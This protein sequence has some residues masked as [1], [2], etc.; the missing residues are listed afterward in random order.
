MLDFMLYVQVSVSVSSGSNVLVI[1]DMTME[2]T[3]RPIFEERLRQLGSW[4]TIN[5]Q[6]IYGIQSWRHTVFWPYLRIQNL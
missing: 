4:L 1:L 3:I 6:A 2:G 5:G